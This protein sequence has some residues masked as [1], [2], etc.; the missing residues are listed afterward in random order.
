MSTVMRTIRGQTSRRLF[1]IWL[2]LI[3]ENSSPGQASRHEV[4]GKTV[5]GTR[6]SV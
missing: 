2:Q 5:N 3:A 1:L 6:C 4:G